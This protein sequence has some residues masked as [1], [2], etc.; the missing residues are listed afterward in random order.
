MV[1]STFQTGCRC[2]GGDCLKRIKEL[3]QDLGDRYAFCV[4]ISERE[5]CRLQKQN[6]SAIKMRTAASLIAGC[7]K[8]EAV[9]YCQDG[10]LQLGY[11]VFVKDAP[12]SPE[13]IC[14]SSPGDRVSLKESEMLLVLDR[15]VRQS[16]LSYTECCFQKLDGRLVKTEKKKVEGTNGCDRP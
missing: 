7:V 9:L 10:E 15:V 16:G 5:V 12:D 2:E 3:K 11:D 1:P 8:I 4:W 13:W 14:Y 6:P